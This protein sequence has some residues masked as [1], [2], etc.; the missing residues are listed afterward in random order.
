[1]A[2]SKIKLS[3]TQI[4]AMGAITL[5]GMSLLGWGIIHFFTETDFFEL[6]WHGEPI[7]KQILRGVI[8]GI[9]AFFIVNVFLQTKLLDDLTGV[10]YD[11]ADQLTWLDVVYISIAAGIGEEILFRIGI[12]YFL[13]VWPTAF[14]FIL[15]HGYFS[16]SNWR[17]TL[18]GAV[19]TII[20]AAFGF[21][22]IKYGIF[23]AMA[24]HAVID[25]L[26]LGYLKLQVRKVTDP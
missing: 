14:L 26:I 4:N 11:L 13:G 3:R 10:I 19:M 2:Q 5:F 18:Y 16:I 9:A 12:Q 17:V 7:W 21:M 23:T 15:I 25:L 6:L 20:S 24:A 8:Y 22:F 1:M